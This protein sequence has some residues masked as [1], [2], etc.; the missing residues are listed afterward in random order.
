MKETYKYIVAAIVLLFSACSNENDDFQ[1]PV[2]EPGKRETQSQF[3]S[4]L[5][6]YE[7]APGQHIELLK[8]C[9]P[10]NIIGSNKGTVLLGGWGGHIVVGFDH[11]VRNTG[12]ADLII[13]C[14]ASV[15]PEPGIVYVMDDKNGNGLP[16]DTW[17]EIKGSKTG[18]E[19]YCSN[20]SVTY[21][22]PAS[23][24]GNVSW[25]DNAGNQG[26][27]PNSTTWWW[28]TDKDSVRYTGTK[29][30]D[31]YYNTPQTNGQ[32]YWAVKQHL[33]SYGYAENG[34]APDRTAENG[35]LAKDYDSDLRGNRIELDS[36]ID[37]QGQPV[38][39]QNIRFVKVQTGVFQ[40]AGWLGEIS[41]EINGI[42]DLH[43]LLNEQ[44]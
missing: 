28:H 12:G 39:L 11:E 8:K 33:F 41:T 30:P 18:K 3:V 5:F 2:P 42:A 26:D 17:Y 9:P 36:A 38:K 15:S 37:N 43:L 7:Y 21:Y 16:D 44:P 20:Y 35:F 10:D 24:S 25:K 19:G 6:N 14:N 31:A 32:Q 34:P 22:R 13:F 1:E 40:Q 29:L 4:T 23:D 27:L